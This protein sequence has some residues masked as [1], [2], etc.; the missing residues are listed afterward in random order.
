MFDL[1]EYISL[2]NELTMKKEC[3][4]Y[5]KESAKN[6]MNLMHIFMCLQT[7]LENYV[8]DICSILIGIIGADRN[9]AVNIIE[10]LN[11]VE[12][13]CNLLLIE[14][15]VSCLMNSNLDEQCNNGEETDIDMQD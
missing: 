5:T 9:D 6:L 12:D 14:H 13:K 1:E 11:K 8:D 4:K 3:S 2:Q 7:N 15:S 10:E